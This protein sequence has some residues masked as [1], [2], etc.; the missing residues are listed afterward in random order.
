MSFWAIIWGRGDIEASRVEIF[1]LLCPPWS[2]S[3]KGDD[4]MFQNV[5][6][7]I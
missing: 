7:F 1:D 3:T 6:F 2:L 5:V 4:P